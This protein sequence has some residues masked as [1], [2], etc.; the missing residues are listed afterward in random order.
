MV[1][2]TSI[3]IATGE[4][5]CS[6]WDFRSVLSDGIAVASP[7]SATPTASPRPVASPRW[8]RRATSWWPRTARSARSPS[9]PASNSTSPSPT[10]SCRNRYWASATAT[11]AA[12]STTWPT[13]HPSRFATATSTARRHP[14]S[15]SPSTRTRS[16]PPPNA[17]TAGA[18][19]S[20]A[21]PTAHWPPGSRTQ[22]HQPARPT[23]PAPAPGEP[24]R[25]PHPGGRGADLG[26]GSA[27]AASSSAVPD[28]ED[29]TDGP[30][31]RL[32]CP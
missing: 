6:R 8:Q 28:F 5:L 20:G 27:Q 1:R 10:S 7:T 29:G 11:A 4:R 31:F 23:L 3:P 18:V 15:A 9:P 21:T 12:I 14:V 26:V 25:L 2:S 17:A 32:R 22:D 16:A 13:R 24:A 19:R 30:A